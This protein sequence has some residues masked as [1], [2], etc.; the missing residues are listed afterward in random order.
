MGVGIDVCD[1]QRFAE[2]VRRRPGLVGRLFTPAEAERPIASQAARFAAKEAV[3]KA[4]GLGIGADMPLAGIE[5]VGEPGGA[6]RLR[7]SEAARAALRPP[8]GGAGH[9][10]ISHD[11][12]LAVAVVFFPA[13]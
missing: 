11:A 7:L 9:V 1:V 4:A 3:L 2:S 5:I 13:T 6:P 8:N 12:G 10:S